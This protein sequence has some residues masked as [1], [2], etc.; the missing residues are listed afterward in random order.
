MTGCVFPD[1]LLML[2]W[3]RLNYGLL[4]VGPEHLKLDLVYIHGLGWDE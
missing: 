1:I 3:I 4:K 2:G